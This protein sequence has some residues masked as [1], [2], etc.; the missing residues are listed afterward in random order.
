ME[1]RVT[2]PAFSFGWN[3]IPYLFKA[4]PLL[5]F[6]GYK[7][8]HTREESRKGYIILC[9]QTGE[10]FQRVQNAKT[11]SFFFLAR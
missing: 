3:S 10:L 2:A 6:F 8:T 7:D 4:G 5:H 9:F 11:L 1:W